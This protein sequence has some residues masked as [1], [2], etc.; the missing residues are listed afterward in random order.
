ML[1]G[2]PHN[3]LPD[4]NYDV[5]SRNIRHIRIG[6]D[7]I[8]FSSINSHEK[9]RVLASLDASFSAEIMNYIQKITKILDKVTFFEELDA[10]PFKNIKL[11]P[12]NDSIIQYLSAIFNYNLMN[13]YELEYILIR[14]LR[15][16][17]KDLENLTIN[18]AELHLNLYKKELEM[19]E[20]EQKKH[21]IEK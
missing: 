12:Y 4:E 5:I 2:L 16:S 19:A 8:D 13:M 3:L 14:R 7:K 20:E 17:L 9:E 6:N 10:N 21:G 1:I 15:F 11:N 18:E